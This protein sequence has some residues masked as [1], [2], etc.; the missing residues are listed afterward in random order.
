MQPRRKSCFQTLNG[1]TYELWASSGISW[2]D[3]NALATGPG[4]Y[5]ATFTSQAETDAVYGSLIGS[6]FF[7][8]VNGQ[9]NEAWLGGF[10][11]DPNQST[12]NP[13][14]WA[15]VTGEQWTAFDAGNFG[16]GEP[17]G[18]ST[19]LAINRFGTTAWNDESGPV[20]GYIVEKE[21]ARIPDSASTLALPGSACTALAVFRRKL[22]L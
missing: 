11:T 3:A 20:G 9:A 14:A 17:K 1:H 7:Q 5:L 4:S 12:T 13:N 6:G 19:G 8:A 21:S 2:V 10:T 16:P 15:W 22:S 18:D